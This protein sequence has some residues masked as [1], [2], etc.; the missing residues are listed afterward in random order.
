MPHLDGYLKLAVA[1]GASDLHF[2][3]NQPVRLRIDGD[4][5]T[6]D[7]TILTGEQVEIIFFE[8]LSEEE[9]QR[10]IEKRNLDRSYR[11]DGLGSFRLNL[12]MTRAGIAAVLRSIPSKIP[13]IEELGLPDTLKDLASSS[14]GLVLVT[15]PTGSGKST[16]LAA[17]IHHINRNCPY[18]ILTAEDPVEFVHPSL[19]SLVNQREI[20]NSCPSFADAL[21]YA[22]RE[23][24]DV[25]LVGEMRD[26]E[27]ISLALTAAETGH[28][29]F[30]TLHTRGAAASVDRVIDSFPANQQSMI[31]AMLSESLIAVI[32]QVLLKK[33][34]GRGRVAAYE[35]MIVNHAISNLI[36]EGKTF[37]ITSALQT[38]KK[39]G[40]ILMDQHIRDLVSSGQVTVEE[41]EAYVENP[42]VLSGLGRL[43]AKGG[44][45]QP[46]SARPGAPRP[47]G[48]AVAPPAI[49]GARPPA[50]PALGRAGA[51]GAP[52][53]LGKAP[54]A[55]PPAAPTPLGRGF[56]PQPLQMGENTA[57]EIRLKPT[58]PAAPP[59]PSA[60]AKPVEPEVGNL[61]LDLDA[62]EEFEIT[63]GLSDDEPSSAPVAP[64]VPPG[65]KKKT[66]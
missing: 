37:Q 4:L 28:L 7:A 63:P 5:V 39:E 22:L 61:A 20:G 45:S 62:S 30:G 6:I 9:R 12:F 24:P 65:Y 55:P 16:T 3:A 36:R 21:K 50:P 40:M 14:R 57:A 27:T 43:G 42:A 1:Q 46:S 58:P 8:I 15:G 32:S 64:G 26:L 48:G 52:P 44:V 13:T 66:G 17:M 23:D 34:S 54:P 19:K 60:A 49:G 18:H 10:F 56:T 35:I 38:G 31:R 29:V 41:A 53:G 11:L 2:S 59:K 25:I 33:A 51:P 47:P